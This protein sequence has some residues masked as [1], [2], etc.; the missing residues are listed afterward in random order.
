MLI[1]AIVYAAQAQQYVY[2]AVVLDR[3][4]APAL[5]KANPVGSGYS[6]CNYTFNPGNK[7]KGKRE[8]KTKRKENRVNT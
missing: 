3:K 5:S 1:A 4:P 7:K 6:P 2:D 8:R